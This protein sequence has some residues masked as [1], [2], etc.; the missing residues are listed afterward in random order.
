MHFCKLSVNNCCN[1]EILGEMR[2]NSG[3]SATL[4]PRRRLS[5][6][7]STFPRGFPH[8]DLTTQVPSPL[9]YASDLSCCFFAQSP[10]G[11]CLSLWIKSKPLDTFPD[12]PL[13]TLPVPSSTISPVHPTS[14]PYQTTTE[15][16][17][18]PVPFALACSST[19]WNAPAPLAC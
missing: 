5:T 8:M 4:I 15:S 1:A 12:Q 6:L 17:N 7:R 19:Q 9:V 11:L 2:R 13:P 10:W 14:H 16:S 3:K 18:V